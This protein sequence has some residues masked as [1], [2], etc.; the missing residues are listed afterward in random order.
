MMTG[1]GGS[2]LG[3][4]SIFDLDVFGIAPSFLVD[5]MVLFCGFRAVCMG[6]SYLSL[7]V[8][9][10]CSPFII[11]HGLYFFIGDMVNYYN[12][13]FLAN[14]CCFDDFLGQ[15]IIVNFS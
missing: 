10:H 1:W 15:V 2:S 8:L 7:S 6:T 4:E 9:C 14:E 11:E 13:N 12:N 3:G 5:C